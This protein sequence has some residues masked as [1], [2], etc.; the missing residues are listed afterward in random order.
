M[1]QTINDF[2]TSF[3]TNPVTMQLVQKGFETCIDAL[4]GEDQCLMECLI[5]ERVFKILLYLFSYSDKK[6]EVQK[7]Y[8]GT[9]GKLNFLIDYFQIDIIDYLKKL[10]PEKT[11]VSTSTRLTAGSLLNKKKSMLITQQ[12]RALNTLTKTDLKEVSPLTAPLL[13]RKIERKETQ[14]LI[15]AIERVQRSELDIEEHCQEKPQ[16]YSENPP[17][18]QFFNN[19]NSFLVSR[20]N[21]LSELSEIEFR[22]IQLEHDFLELLKP[23]SSNKDQQKKE[24]SPQHESEMELDERTKSFQA[25]PEMNNK[26]IQTETNSPQLQKEHFETLIRGELTNITEIN[27]AFQLIRSRDFFKIAETF[28]LD[29]VCFGTNI[30]N[31]LYRCQELAKSKSF[32]CPDYFKEII[33]ILKMCHNKANEYAHP[34]FNLNSFL[35][36]CEIFLGKK[37]KIFFSEVLK[38]VELY[39][40]I[41]VV[42]KHYENLNSKN[43]DE[44]LAN[45]L[46]SSRNEWL[47]K[48]KNFATKV[49]NILDNADK[50]AKE[51]KFQYKSGYIQEQNPMVGLNFVY[52]EIPAIGFN[53]YPRIPVISKK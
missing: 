44:A 1:T 34:N 48:F 23:Q 53:D 11:R 5:T 32:K 21:V 35:L 9:L 43:Y 17:S 2:S 42:A 8:P 47:Q 40:Y 38:E 37:Y 10:I 19:D 7:T 49:Q 6:N 29:I 50:K 26:E 31:P 28:M 52:A 39:N 46:D 4:N 20:S 33:E 24:N 18:G 3:Q 16:I 36:L 14:E 13:N 45:Q 51:S 22:S 41:K 15:E 30:T 25:P 12:K 27:E